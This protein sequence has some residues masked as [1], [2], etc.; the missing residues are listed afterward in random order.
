MKNFLKV[1]LLSVL[2]TS[3][4]STAYAIDNHQAHIGHSS[5]A[6]T[7]S[8]QHQPINTKGVV[9]HVDTENKKLTI[10]HEPIKTLGWP[11]MTMRFTYEDAGMIEDIKEGDR[12]ELDFIQKGNISLISK[13][14]I[15]K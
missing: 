1:T 4:F 2:S 5:N 15:L 10:T 12:V 6:N 3:I 13:I 14:V 9:E 7:V 8:V 11:S